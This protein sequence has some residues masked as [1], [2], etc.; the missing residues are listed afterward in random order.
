[1]NLTNIFAA[2]KRLQAPNIE[3]STL[4]GNGITLALWG[5]GVLSVAIILYAAFRIITAR[6]D[7]EKVKKGR[8]AITWGMVGLGVTLLAGFIISIVRNVLG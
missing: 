4:L 6:G 1:M 3:A 8:L 2:D 7:A 5:I